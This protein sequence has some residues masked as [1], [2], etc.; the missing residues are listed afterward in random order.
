M[1]KLLDLRFVIGGGLGYIAIKTERTRLDVLGGVAYNREKFST[2][3]IRNSAD[4][5]W[6]DNLTHK[7]SK[8][9]TL[10]QSFRLFGNLNELGEY[11]MNFDLGTVTNLNKWLAWQLTVSDRYLSNPVTGRQRNDV[12][13]TTGVRVSFAR[14]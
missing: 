14:K 13:L 5:Y 6:G 7:I 10:T 8:V 12:L 1:N 9:T 4:G 11:R 2:P 3:L